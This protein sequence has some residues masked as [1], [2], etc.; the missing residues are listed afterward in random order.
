VQCLPDF[1]HVASLTIAA[2]RCARRGRNK[3]RRP[4]PPFFRQCRWN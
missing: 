4:K 2:A 1:R 3:K